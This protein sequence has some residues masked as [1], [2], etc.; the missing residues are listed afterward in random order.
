MGK[1]TKGK[2]VPYLVL[3]QNYNINKKNSKRHSVSTIVKN[4]NKPWWIC[5]YYYSPIYSFTELSDCQTSYNNFI[6]YFRKYIWES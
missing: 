3:R 6:N 5:C 2:D 1:M 4:K